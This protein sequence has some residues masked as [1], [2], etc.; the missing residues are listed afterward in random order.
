MVTPEIITQIEQRIAELEAQGVAWR[1]ADVVSA[2]K[3][4]RTEKIKAYLRD[5]RA[6]AKE[7]QG[8]R[9]D[10]ASIEARSP[11]E[12]HEGNSLLVSQPEAAVPDSVPVL[13]PVAAADQALQQAEAAL[14]DARDGLLTAK[15]RLMATGNLNVGG[16]LRGSLHAK[17]DEQAQALEEVAFAKGAYDEAWQAR[18][19]ARWTLDTAEKQHR[20]QHQEAWVR[21][22]RSYLVQN[23][24]YWEAKTRTATGP[25]LAEAKKNYELLQFAYNTELERTP[26]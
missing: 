8:E 25:M 3:G 10:L 21:V 4:I 26:V 9:T 20:R 14:C 17:D 18:D 13:D 24:A 12:G 22:H 7:R 2:V 5:R 11:D 15:L 16:I 1:N 19:Q 23:L 6:Q